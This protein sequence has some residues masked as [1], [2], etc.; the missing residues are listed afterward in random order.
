MPTWEPIETARKDN[1]AILVWCPENKCQYMVVW[2]KSTGTWVIFGGGNALRETP[3]HWRD[4]PFNPKDEN[5]PP[6]SEP[7]R[8]V[9]NCKPDKPGI[10]A[11]KYADWNGITNISGIIAHADLVHAASSGV[12]WCYL[13][14]IPE[15][16]PPLKK[17]V[18][19]LWLLVGRQV[20]DKTAMYLQQWMDGD[21]KPY[22]DADWI[23]TDETREVEQ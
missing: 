12:H 19:R 16:L 2:R 21:S 22:G 6:P 5:L 13:G 14:P 10:W 8:W 17:V 7:L 3:T 9:E 18:Q 15:I 20:D 23:R 4:L 1:K 11:W